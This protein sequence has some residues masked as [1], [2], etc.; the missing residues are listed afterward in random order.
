MGSETEREGQEEQISSFRQALTTPY[1]PQHSQI[2][3]SKFQARLTMHTSLLNRSV[4]DS[5][6]D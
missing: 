4:C 2:I 5:I 1:W 3:V 6:G